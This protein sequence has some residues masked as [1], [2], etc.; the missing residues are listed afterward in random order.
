[1]LKK[2]EWHKKPSLQ[3]RRATKLPSF[4]FYSKAVNKPRSLVVKKIGG[5]KN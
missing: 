2:P 3:K 4:L 5:K 1:M